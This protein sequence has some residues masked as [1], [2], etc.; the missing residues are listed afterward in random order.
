ML[1]QIA[2][3]PLSWLVKILAFGSRL[4]R[5]GSGTSISGLLVEKYFPWVIGYFEG[6]FEEV[7]YISGTNG[8]TTVRALAVRI[9]EE[10]GVGVTSNIGGANIFRGIA[11]SLILNTNWL[12]VPKNK[13][14]ILE[15]EEATL[16]RLTSYL[17]PTKLVLTNIFRDQLDAYGEIDATLGFFSRAIEL[18]GPGLEIVANFDDKKLLNSIPEGSQITA[19]SVFDENKIG[20]EATETNT[21]LKIKNAFEAQNIESGAGNTKF[22]VNTKGKQLKITT[23]L[24]GNYNISNILAAA[25]IA[26]PRFKDGIVK[27]IAN[28]LPVFGR[29]EEVLVGDNKIKLFLVKNP[30]GFDQVLEYISGDAEPKNIAFVINDNIADGKDVSWLW[31]IGLEKFAQKNKLEKLYTSGTRGLDMLLRLEYTGQKVIAENNYK[32]ISE[33]VEK[34]V[35]EDQTTYMLCTYTALLSLRKELAR[36]VKMPKITDSGN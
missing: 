10:N 6:K 20:Y 16:P 32:T 15:V 1:L 29:G 35:D 13:V 5:K 17:K 34:L 33:L 9:Y 24:P 3:I 19:F 2:I 21:K 8:K 11:S 7:V 26:Y 4:A 12:G 31:D 23:L 28:F 18:A 27:S 25:A 36:Y 14:A 22:N 30:A